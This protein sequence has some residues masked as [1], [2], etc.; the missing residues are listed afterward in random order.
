M[1][2]LELPSQR[3]ARP[4]L[5][6]A[7]IALLLGSMAGLLAAIPHA[8]PQTGVHLD[9]LKLRPLHTTFVI[10]WIFLALQGALLHFVPE[11]ARRDWPYPRLIKTQFGLMAAAGCL[12]LGAY[13]SGHMTGREYMEFPI[14]VSVLIEAAWALFLINFFAL[15]RHVPRPWPAYIWMWATGLVLFPLIL[16]EGHL[17]LLP[18]YGGNAIRDA[19]VQ[20]KVGGSLVGSWN[21]VVYGLSLFLTE[22][23]TGDRKVGSNAEAYLLFWLGLTNLMFNFAHH[24]YPL[25]QALWIRELAYAVSMTEWLVLIHI[26]VSRLRQSPQAV[27]KWEAARAFLGSSAAWTGINLL[28][29]L[30]ISIPV[31]NGL[32]HGTYIT[33]AHSMGTTIG[34]NS[35]ILWAVGFAILL[36]HQQQ[37]SAWLRSSLIALN[38]ALGV[39]FISLVLAG[40]ASSFS[41]FRQGGDFYSQMAAARPFLVAMVTSGGA[42]LVGIGLVGVLWLKYLFQQIPRPLGSV[43]GAPALTMADART[44]DS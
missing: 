41:H 40:M 23:L 22:R 14:L 42:L 27:P 15:I 2:P 43:P 38:G 34:I 13:L 28:L 25:P 24:T 44:H 26:I 4:F 10:A 6:S 39:F 19:A 32:T 17:Y 1:K 5:A 18:F 29:A 21:Q 16:I 36:E 12:A 35:M 7:A 9:L 31:L 30:L 33:V 11:V 20:W 37:G 8:W 3:L